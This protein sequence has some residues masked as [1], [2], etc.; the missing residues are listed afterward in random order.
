MIR[1]IEAY[2]INYKFTANM[3]RFLLFNAIFQKICL[4]II[5]NF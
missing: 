2:D 3:Y 4:E 5:K 1:F